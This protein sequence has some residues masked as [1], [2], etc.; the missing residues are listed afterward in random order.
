MSSYVVGPLRAA[1]NFAPF[2][3]FRKNGDMYSVG[4]M[5]NIFIIELY[6]IGCTLCRC[7]F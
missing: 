5:F 3:L 6:C 4:P 1:L 2:E 7:V